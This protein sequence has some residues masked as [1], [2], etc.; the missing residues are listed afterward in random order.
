MLE[1][2]FDC[3]RRDVSLLEDELKLG[4]AKNTCT[5]GLRD[6][7]QRGGRGLRVSGGCAVSWKVYGQ[8]EGVQ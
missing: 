7:M 1:E 3:W 8:F 4:F 6:G 2:D 5:A